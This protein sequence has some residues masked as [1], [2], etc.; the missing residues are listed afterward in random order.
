MVGEFTKEIHNLTSSPLLLSRSSK[1]EKP[2]P[3]PFSYCQVYQ[4][5]TSHEC[6]L[7]VTLQISPT[8]V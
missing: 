5:L 4:A 2:H 6:A 8:A 3:V 7:V 1:L